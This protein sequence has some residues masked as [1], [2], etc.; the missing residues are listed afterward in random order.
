M[1]KEAPEADVA[2]Q[3]T[4]LEPAGTDPEAPASERENPRLPAG[5]AEVSEA[6]VLEQAQQVPDQDDYRDA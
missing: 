1:D 3:D 5:A 6:D 2:E 4:E